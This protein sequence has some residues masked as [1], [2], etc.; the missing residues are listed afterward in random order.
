MD[1][2]TG[3]QHL[4][5]YKQSEGVEAY[6]TIHAWFVS[7]VTSVAR[8][9]KAE[10]CYCHSCHSSGPRLH[11]C[12]SCIFFSCWGQHLKEHA[13]S[14][15]HRLW[16]DLEY[17]QVFCC[18]CDDYVYD[19]DLT[20][21]SDQ[22]KAQCHS[23]LGLGVRHRRWE[24]TAMEVKLLQSN[25]KRKGFTKNSTIGLRGL[26]NLG[27]TCFMNCIV[28]VLIHT[29]LLR[30]HFLSDRHLCQ[31]SH[32]TNQCIVCE[33]NRLFQEF[34]SGD[35]SP[36]SLHKLLYMIWTHAHHLAGYEQQDAHEFFI[37][38]LDLL[39]RHLIH[40][41]NIPPSACTCIVDSIFTGKLQS[42]VVC[43]VCKGVSTTVD[44]FWDISL[45]LPTGALQNGVVQPISLQDC[46]QRFTQPENLGSGAKIR[47]ST[48]KS[49]Q[50]STKQ[51]TMQKL[52]IVA[53]FHLKRF[54]HSSAN[55]RP[56]A[57]RLHKKITT[58][59]N[60]PEML[61]MSPFISHSRNSK[62]KTSN[63]YQS[64]PRDNKYVLFAVINHIGT[65]DA[66]HYTSYIRQHSNL[67]F[68]CND[69]QILPASIQQVLDSE[70][71][72]LFYHK[73][74]LEYK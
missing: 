12:L 3:C 58:R 17:G 68:H 67:W 25:P 13:R 54:E 14:S 6:R 74:L 30:D 70:G 7:P 72:L 1:A 16:I 45:D 32:E 19:T 28:Q 10:S 11:S 42:D 27:H 55:G 64:L 59:V 18:L 36:L 39:H 63:S 62:L 21:I 9:K 35:G 65:L 23:Q 37:A 4:Q 5:R 34:F 49:H 69:H 47:C 51:L 40:K 33:F 44:P 20:S 43:Q 24:P 8:K 46:L 31:F 48:C 50:E 29:P 56:G 60:F 52:P 22:H 53:S 41:T 61:D 26:I 71:Y 2:A 73:Q 15:Q 66:G 57:S 38:T